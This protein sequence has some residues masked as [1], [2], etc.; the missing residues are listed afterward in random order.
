MHYMLLFVKCIIYKDVK[1]NKEKSAKNT[2][3][4]FYK[5]VCSHWSVTMK[6]LLSIVLFAL[7]P[8]SSYAESWP[9]PQCQ[10]EPYW[11]EFSTVKLCTPKQNVTHLNILHSELP[12]FTVTTEHG[13]VIFQIQTAE[14]ITGGLHSKY[15]LFIFNKSSQHI[16]H[17]GGQF[18]SVEAKTLLAQ[19]RL[20]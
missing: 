14:N 7:L 20:P 6:L 2:V 16:L 17:I 1:M 11:L 3:S 12:S 19:F 9:K 5:G 13:E 15:E 8:T 18:D 4:A 10:G